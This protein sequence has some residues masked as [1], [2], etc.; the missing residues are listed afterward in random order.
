MITD[1][2]LTDG[3]KEAVAHTSGGGKQH[4]TAR[5]LITT[6]GNALFKYSHEQ[7]D[8]DR[9]ANEHSFTSLD[10]RSLKIHTVSNI[11]M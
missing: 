1:L 2:T 8:S 6:Y 7:R 5:V 9:C 11:S 3:D 4:D 10:V